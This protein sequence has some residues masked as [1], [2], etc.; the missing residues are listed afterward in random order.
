MAQFIKLLATASVLL[1]SS[2]SNA[3]PI[4]YQGDLTLA[5]TV[6]STLEKSHWWFFSANAGDQVTIQANRREIEMD[7]AFVLY[8]GK[9][10]DDLNLTSLAIADD[11]IDVAGPYGDPK[12]VYDITATG[13]YSIRIF[14]FFSWASN[15]NLYDYSISVVGSSADPY[16]VSEPAALGILALAAFG[17]IGVR[18]RFA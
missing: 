17:A 7:P 8:Q 5:G 4:S 18:R 3:A 12:L 11:E 6:N 10:S 16:A 14:S 13:D 15:D 9:S 1:L 2:I